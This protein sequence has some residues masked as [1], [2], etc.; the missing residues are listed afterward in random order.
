MKRLIYVIVFV[1]F[2]F[3]GCEDFLNKTDPTATSFVEFYND[4]EDLR[5]V[6]YS[7]YLDVFTNPQ[8]RRA[9]CYMR[10]GRSDNPYARI[11]ADHHQSIA[12]GTLDRNT[13]ALEYYYTLYMKHLG[14]LNTFSANIDEPYV[15][16][17]VVRTKY[18]Y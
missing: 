14:R 13:R 3:V 9:V 10:D 17:E 15:E 6:V 2:N 5:R 4:E 8:N 7:S 18:Q 1:S 16:D 12:N 11:E